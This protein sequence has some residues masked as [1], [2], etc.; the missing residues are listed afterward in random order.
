M[1]SFTIPSRVGKIKV[2]FLNGGTLIVRG[3][4]ETPE[5]HRV[6]ETVIDV[7]DHSY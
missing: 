6:I 5:F 3:E 1:E 7:L 2:A 4:K